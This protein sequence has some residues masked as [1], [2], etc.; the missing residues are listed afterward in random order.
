MMQMYGDASRRPVYAV[1]HQP[2]KVGWRC[3]TIIPIYFFTSINPNTHRVG[4]TI[5]AA[6]S[7]TSTVNNGRL[8]AHQGDPKDTTQ[9]PLLL[10]KACRTTV[11]L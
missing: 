7:T 10:T 8:V 2:R 4:N 6:N 5:A 3:N 9:Q 11:E 1:E